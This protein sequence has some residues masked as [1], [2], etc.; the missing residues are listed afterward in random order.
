M[1]A[2]AQAPIGD[3]AQRWIF[4]A[5]ALAFLIKM[6]SFPFHGWMPDGYRNMPLPVLAVF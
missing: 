1:S 5:F 3:S 2:L 6:P 4:V